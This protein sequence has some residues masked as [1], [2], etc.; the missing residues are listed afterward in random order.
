MRSSFFIVLVNITNNFNGFIF[1]ELE[2]LFF[3]DLPIQ[4][5]RHN[6][7]V[8]SVQIQ[9]R[10]NSVFGHFSHSKC[11]SIHSVHFFKNCTFKEE[12]VAETIC[13]ERNLVAFVTFTS[14]FDN[15]RKF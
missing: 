1:S 13:R 15:F 12:N 9:T 4:F 6:H 7:F 8:K 11:Y 10:K 2:Q 3:V 5:I 14:V